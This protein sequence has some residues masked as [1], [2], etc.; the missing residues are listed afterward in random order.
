MIIG[1]SFLLSA[2]LLVISMSLK[3]VVLALKVSLKALE[4]T[5]KLSVKAANSVSSDLGLNLEDNAVVNAARKTKAG[6]QKTAD[7]VKKTGRTIQK[8]G[9]AAY[10]TAKTTGKVAYKTAKTTYKAGKTAVKVAIKT[11]KLLI[12][13]LQL[14]INLIHT[15]VAFLLSLGVVGIVIL[16]VIILFL[17]A[18]IAGALLASGELT[19]L[20]FAVNG[21]IQPSGTVGG[22]GL[23]QG[24]VSGVV[25]E[26]PSSPVSVVTPGD[27]QALL[28]A[29]EKLGRWYMA[30][31][32]TYC[33]GPPGN[34]AGVVKEYQCSNMFSFGDWKVGD[35]CIRFGVAYAALVSGKKVNYWAPIANLANGT[36]QSFIDA[37][38]VYYTVEQIGGVSGLQPG[39]I[40]AGV[41]GDAKVN[42]VGAK[43][44]HVE[45]Y[46]GPGKSFGW[47]GVK[48]S[49]PT[50]RTMVDEVRN[51]KTYI[52]EVG[53]TNYHFYS[54]VWRYAG[55]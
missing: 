16:V 42:G 2:V 29:C 1:S 20:L 13:G 45:V 39:D 17:V 33:S 35:D 53:L 55:G 3:T 37:G 12:K 26:N 38:W 28:D 25:S 49:Y 41:S 52:T 6:V 14:L 11:I 47:G 5:A 30:N 34:P 24:I 46:L 36:E 44:N 8:T 22:I 43:Y 31:V 10:K 32:T 19:H 15:V 9:K 7:T 54:G 40:V 23:N 48:T 21:G 4:K 18:A 27:T 51:G 50:S